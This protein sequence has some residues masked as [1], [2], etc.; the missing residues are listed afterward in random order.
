[1]NEKKIEKESQQ[2]KIFIDAVLFESDR[3]ED[4]CIEDEKL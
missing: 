4:E 2:N 1:M 3:H